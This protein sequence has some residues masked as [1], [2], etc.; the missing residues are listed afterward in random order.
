MRAVYLGHNDA[1]HHG[2]AMQQLAKP[3]ASCGLNPHCCIW[4]PQWH[5]ACCST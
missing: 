2:S 5:C 1:A 3:L 4:D